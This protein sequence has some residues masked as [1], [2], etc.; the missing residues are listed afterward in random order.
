MSCYLLPQHPPLGLGIT[1]GSSVL[2]GGISTPSRSIPF[3][4]SA[5]Q[6]LITLCESPAGTGGGHRGTSMILNHTDSK[7]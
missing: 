6:Q 1:P 2:G 5:S 3:A 7:A 4:I